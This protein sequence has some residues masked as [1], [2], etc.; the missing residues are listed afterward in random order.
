[1]K[2]LF[3]FGCSFTQFYWPTWADILGKEFDYFENWGKVGAGNMYIA[4]A[5]VES[6][7]KNKFTKADTIMIMWS[8]MTREDRYLDKNNKWM[9]G[10]NIYS[11]NCYDKEFVKKYVHVRGCYIR[12]LAQ[13]YL[14][15]Q[16][17]EKIGCEHE[18]MSIV[19]LKN[20]L[21]FTY[22]DASE[23]VGDLLEFYKDTLSKFKPS[24]H[25]TVFNCRWASKSTQPN[26]KRNDPH[27]IPSE[28]LE[29]L[30]KILPKFTI[31]EETREWVSKEDIIARNL[32]VDYM[33]PIEQVERL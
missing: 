27:P 9:T 31:S 11:Y 6:A 1:M 3:T 15:S 13:I 33:I 10:G 20:S 29:Y 26:G 2:R 30:D 17:L 5:V 22:K 19:D 32:T 7:I 12:D 4:N 24:V 16:Y 14:I 18:F 25:S 21:Q 8:S 23:D 28:Y